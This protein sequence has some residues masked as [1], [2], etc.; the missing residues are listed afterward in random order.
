MTSIKNRVQL[1]GT[2]GKDPEIKEL[3]SGKKLAR[4]VMAT[5]ENYRSSDGE[6]MTDTQWHDLVAWD[7]VAGIIEKYLKKG[8]HAGVEGKLVNRSYTDKEGVKQYKTEVVVNEVM[9]F[10][11]NGNPT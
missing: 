3:E 5:N 1:I 4:F 2:L 11:Q 6:K 8:H 7:G 10:P 9:L